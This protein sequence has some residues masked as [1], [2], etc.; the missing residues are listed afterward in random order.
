[1]RQEKVGAVMSTD[2]V[3]ARRDT[4]FKEVARLLRE[5]RISG[6]PVV[7][8]EERVLGVV[9]RTDL[10]AHQATFG[11]PSPALRR[12]GPPGWTTAARRRAAKATARTAGQLMTSPALVVHADDTVIEAATLM[13]ERDVAR[14]PVLDEEDRLVGI[15]TR[16][17]LL[18]VFLKPDE[19]IH[20]EVAD[21]VLRRTL[22]L[23]PGSVHV[24]VTDGVV[25]L[26]GNMER[27]SD[28]RLAVSMTRKVS[29]VIAVV[30]NLT[31]RQDDARP[32]FQPRMVHHRVDPT[33]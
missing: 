25:T 26:T 12:F 13:T 6:L 33:M 32:A 24:D 3:G 31:Y 2:I 28:A 5:H 8:D 4:P 11:A 9:S 20:R 15:V 21:D 29:G 22:W 14:L 23:P 18:T 1:M 16:H 19:R 27:R 10:V 30:D 7:D 17:D